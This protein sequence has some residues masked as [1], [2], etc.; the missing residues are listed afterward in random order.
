MIMFQFNSKYETKS[1][2]GATN[3][4][5]LAAPVP[6]S[7]TAVE[8]WLS[9][10]GENSAERLI[11]FIIQYKPASL[12]V[13]VFV[14]QRVP[15]LDTATKDPYYTTGR[16]AHWLVAD[17]YSY[18]AGYGGSPQLLGSFAEPVAQYA[19]LFTL[20]PPNVTSPTPV[21]HATFFGLITTVSHVEHQFEHE[22][23]V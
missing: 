3:Q 6:T 4:I 17:T 16:T 20:E 23:Y 8:T 15:S 7:P 11:G 19:K 21:Y 9:I 18:K 14:N 1:R 10:A 13:S 2:V 12:L 5:L 22:G